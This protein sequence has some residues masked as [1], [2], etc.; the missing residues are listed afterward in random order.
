MSVF[1]VQDKTPEVYTSTSRDFQLLGRLYDCIINGVKF[2]VDS[3]I[4]VIN[5]D[6]I[7]NKLLKLLQTK[8]GFFSS[9]DITDESLRYILKAFPTI[10]KHKGS[11]KSIKQAV[12]TFLKLNG[13]KSKVS[14]RKVNNNLT[15]PYLIEISL[16]ERIDNTYILN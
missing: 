2:D 16:D 9:K 4:D 13:I 11:L 10:L 1:R 3:V 8:L 12:C 5:T 15:S 7:D 14:I 6:N